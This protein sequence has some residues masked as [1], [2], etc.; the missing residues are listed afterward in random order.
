MVNTRSYPA[1]GKKQKLYK[2]ES[3]HRLLWRYGRTTVNLWL[4]VLK[5]DI[6][7]PT[8]ML[9]QKNYRVCSAHFDEEDFTLCKRPADPKNPMR[10]Y[11]KNNAVPRVEPLATDSVEVT[12][13]IEWGENT[14]DV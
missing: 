12:F 5:I 6:N 10:A 11:L 1:C 2:S 3:F 7:T 13:Y 4:V 14:K 8:D 9:K